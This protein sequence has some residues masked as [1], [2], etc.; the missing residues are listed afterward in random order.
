MR[1]GLVDVDGYNFP[2]LPLMK[3]SAYHKSLGDQVEWYE[4]LKGLI[5]EYD[6]VYISK[7][8]SFSKDYDMPVYAKEVQRGGTGYCITNVNGR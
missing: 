6:K 4:P 2:N 8:F 5:Q 3:I 1:I 7:V